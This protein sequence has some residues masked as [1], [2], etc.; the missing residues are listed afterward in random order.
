MLH[1]PFTSIPQQLEL[2]ESR[3]VTTDS[4]TSWVLE[5]EGYY[6][7]INGYKDLFL[8]K[9]QSATEGQDRYKSGTT[10]KNIYD[11]FV[12]DRSLRFCIFQALTLAE[13]TLKTICAYEFSAV[14][15]DE[16][17]AFLELGFY[18]A[19]DDG[20]VNDK[21]V[22]LI[23]IFKKILELDES[24]QRRN[25]YV[26]ASDRY[27]G[28]SYLRHCMEDHDGEVPMWVLT[29]DLT[30]GQTY[31]FYQIQVPEVRK[32]IAIS[33]TKLYCDSHRHNLDITS[34]KLDKIYRRIKDFR[35]ICAHDERLYCAHP[36][37]DNAT[38]CQLIKDLQFV[39]DKQRYMEFLQHVQ[40][41]VETIC[42]KLPECETGILQ[43]MGF[44]EPN[45]LQ[46][47]LE[48]VR[49]L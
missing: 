24:S 32:N 40:T 39:M 12:F 2:L 11:L 45:F 4:R 49:K 1:K 29:N 44:E 36:H 20:L 21:A 18:A 25:L 33:F 13:A 26:P 34:S 6:S 31:W 42:G 38:L 46:V 9:E 35:N 8:D 43:Q 41:L 19:G 17:N 14:H 10:F 22:T 3:G 28:K 16:K 15:Q 47:H 27:G 37:D 7:I 23:A 48:V 30:L 5:R